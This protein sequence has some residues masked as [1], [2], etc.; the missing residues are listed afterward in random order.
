MQSKNAIRIAPTGN[1]ALA[2]KKLV[3]TPLAAKDAGYFCMLQ[4]E[5]DFWRHYRL[6]EDRT[7]SL[8]QLHEALKAEEG[9]SLLQAQKIEWLINRREGEKLVPIGL[10]ALAHFAAEQRRAEF[11]VG[12]ARRDDRTTGLG[13]EASLLVFDFAFNQCDLNKLTTLVYA[14]ADNAQKDTEALGFV[15]E[16]YLRQHLWDAEQ[17]QFIDLYENGMLQADFRRNSR[18]SRLSRRLLGRDITC[19]N[20]GNA[21]RVLKGKEREGVEA[22]FRQSFKLVANRQT[23]SDEE[24]S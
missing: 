14:V 11:L 19:D 3:L 5:Q 12:I 7:R 20:G 4:N 21:I 13:L 24:S 6:N 17:Q 16:G 18:L 15:Q 22:A 8:E 23:N 9:Q 1:R 2:G 10:A